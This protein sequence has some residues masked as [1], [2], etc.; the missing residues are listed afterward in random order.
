MIIHIFLN[1]LINGVHSFFVIYYSHLWL[2]NNLRIKAHFFTYKSTVLAFLKLNMYEIN[3]VIMS[4]CDQHCHHVINI[5]IV[6]SFDQ[7]CHHV[8]NTAIM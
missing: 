4:S 2:K 7:K 3:I 8:I 6:S 1:V 5:V